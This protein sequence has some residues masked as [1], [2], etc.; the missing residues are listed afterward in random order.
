M[1]SDRPHAAGSR[2][3]TGIIGLRGAKDGRVFE[4]ESGT[5]E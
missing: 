4:T 1:H 2:L 5:A 3:S